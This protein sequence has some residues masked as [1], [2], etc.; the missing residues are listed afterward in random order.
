[1]PIGAP[2]FRCTRAAVAG[3]VRSGVVVATMI[4]SRSA[5]ERPSGGERL[6][7][8]LHRQVRRALIGRGP[9]AL[10]DA[11]ALDDPGVGGVDDLGEVG[12]GDDFFGQ[13]RAYPGDDAAKH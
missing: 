1:M 4:R 11:G 3:N 2:S 5:G 12:V 10:V 6:F 13:I 9:A 7:G 8:R